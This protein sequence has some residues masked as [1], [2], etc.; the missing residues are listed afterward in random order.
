MDRPIYKDQ[1]MTRT[2]INWYFLGS[3][4]TYAATAAAWV[5]GIRWALR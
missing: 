5:A 1:I 2:R 3:L 4:L